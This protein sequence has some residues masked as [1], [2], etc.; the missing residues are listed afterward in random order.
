MCSAHS[1]LLSFVTGRGT[2]GEY[3][4]VSSSFLLEGSVLGFWNKGIGFEE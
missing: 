2:G 1:L 3:V 4:R